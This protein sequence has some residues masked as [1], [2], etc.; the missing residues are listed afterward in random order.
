VRC[1]ISGCSAAASLSTVSTT[2]SVQTV[3]QFHP[4]QHTTRD[5]AW[6]PN[7]LPS[8]NQDRGCYHHGR[9]A[10]RLGIQRRFQHH[11][12]CTP[13]QVDYRLL[14]KIIPCGHAALPLRRRAKI[15]YRPVAS[16]LCRH[17][18]QKRLEGSARSYVQITVPGVSWYRD[19]ASF[20]L[21]ERLSTPSVHPIFH[22]VFAAAR[23]GLA[24]PRATLP[25][26]D[27]TNPLLPKAPG[28]LPFWYCSLAKDWTW[29]NERMKEKRPE[30]SNKK[31]HCL[32]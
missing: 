12:S 5:N 9:S 11:V 13:S 6:F 20:S 23:G 15:Q 3:S 21:T 10:R 29:G 30:K 28:F 24:V 14:R 1:C 22:P 4:T 26:Q 27:D 7:L 18:H 8:R 2:S 19:E 31:T 17:V 32:K 16:Q 25:F